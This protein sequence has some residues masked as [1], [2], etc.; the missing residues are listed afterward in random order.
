MYCLL[1]LPQSLG[2]VSFGILSPVYD[3]TTLVLNKLY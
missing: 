2:V 3:P 1:K